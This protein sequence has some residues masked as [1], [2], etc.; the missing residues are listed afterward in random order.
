MVPRD[1]SSK[2]PA[3]LE[4]S[5]IRYIQVDNFDDSIIQ[6]DNKVDYWKE[7]LFKLK[8]FDLTQFDKIV[9]LDSDMLVLKNLDHL[10]D[11]PHMSSVAAGKELHPDWVKLNSGLMVIEPSHEEYLSLENMIDIVYRERT[12]AGKGIGD[13]D[14]IQAYYDR[15]WAESEQLHLSSVYNT[16]LGY[17]GYLCKSGSISGLNDIYVYHFTGREKPWRNRLI[18]KIV[19]ILKILKR[20]HSR[21]DF[22]VLSKYKEVLRQV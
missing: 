11:M 10:F 1:V 2:I 12:S 4:A 21:I 20:S 8:V 6:R 5:G 19:I 9:F 13:Q 3:E 17:A 22:E 16:M 7:T 18:E 14:V 15:L